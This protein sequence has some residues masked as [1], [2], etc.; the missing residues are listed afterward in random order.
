ME[1]QLPWAKLRCPAP[2]PIVQQPH[3]YLGNSGFLQGFHGCGVIRTISSTN[4]KGVQRKSNL[5]FLS[6]MGVSS[7]SLCVYDVWLRLSFWMFLLSYPGF[8]VP[9]RSLKLGE[10]SAGTQ[11]HLQITW[12][13]YQ[14]RS[15]S[16]S[17]QLLDQ[18]K[19]GFYCTFKN[20]IGGSL[21]EKDS[22]SL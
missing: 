19:E 6:I 2:K 9:S 20:R 7:E 21:F 5:E 14:P 17:A 8:R 16:T 4:K 12:T 13:S 10:K 15:K 11:N 22:L 3:V 18:I 1:F